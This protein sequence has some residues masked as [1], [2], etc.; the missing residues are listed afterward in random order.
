[1]VVDE[2][3]ADRQDN[4]AYPQY[5]AQGILSELLPYLEVVP[6]ETS[7]GYVPE[8]ELWEGFNGLVKGI[9]TDGTTIEDIRYNENGDYD[10]NGEY[11]EDG[12]T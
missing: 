3:N 5:I 4:S 9:N 1:M 2:P 10:E 12:T 7:D 11:D 6:D 8:T